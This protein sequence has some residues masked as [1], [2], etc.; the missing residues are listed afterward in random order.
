MLINF[1]PHRDWTLARE[2]KKFVRT[3]ALVALL[4]L[5]FTAVAGVWL[6]Q[7]LSAQQAANQRLRLEIAAVDSQLTKIKQVK[8]ELVKLKLREAS[9]QALQDERQLTALGLQEV[10]EHLPDGLYL[11]ALKQEGDKLML[12]GMARSD[13]QVF[14]LLQQMASQGRW[15]AQAELTEVTGAPWTSGAL[16][17]TGTPF[18]MRALLKRPVGRDAAPPTTGVRCIRR[19][20]TEAPRPC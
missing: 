4:G 12:N 13:Q 6:D 11:T 17:L 9:L 3:L 19:A 14:Q 2:R 8:E 10:L 16:A 5:L 20:E 18:A 15:L 7:Q 1:L